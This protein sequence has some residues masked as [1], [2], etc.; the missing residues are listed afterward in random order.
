MTKANKEE[1]KQSREIK[2]EVQKRAKRRKHQGEESK[3]QITKKK[4][5]EE[6][7]MGTEYAGE[8]EEDKE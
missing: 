2:K 6:K 7:K 1:V 8:K 4:R 3:K 5:E